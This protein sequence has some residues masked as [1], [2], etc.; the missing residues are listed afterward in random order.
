MVPEL[1]GLLAGLPRADSIAL[2][3][4]KGFFLP[5]GNGAVLV[6][7]GSK[8]KA[9][10][11]AYA[12]YL[13]AATS[14]EFYDMSMYGPELSRPFRGLRTWLTVQLFGAR[15]LRAAIREKRDLALW[16]YHELS[17]VDGL[18]I[19]TEP[20]LSLFPYH[21]T[22]PG[23][24]RQEENLATQELLERVIERGEI[25]LSGCS[26]DGRFL[27]RICVLSFRTRR[28]Q[29]ETCVRQI[30]EEAR[31]ILDERRG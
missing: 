29:V 9:V 15:R 22:W 4:H 14:D 19:V 17:Q 8:L 2:D 7:D 6:R 23:A 20:Q 18:R 31:A 26:V 5:Y 11:A 21:L 12:D 28:G 30:T 3:P 10:H 13:P 27:G 24:T 25:M 16:A 1:R